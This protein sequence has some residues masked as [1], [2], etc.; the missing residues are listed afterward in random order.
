M[1]D[2][3][4]PN[5]RLKRSEK[6][7]LWDNNVNAPPQIKYD[8]F[9]NFR[10]TDIRSGLLSHLIEAFKRNQINA[11]VDD[12]L[13]RGEEI[14]PS[15]VEA[16]ERSQISLI[17]FSEDYA[18]SHWCLE[19]LVT[20]LECRKK[21]GQVVFPIFYH[22]EPRDVGKQSLEKYKKAF[23]EHETKYETK[24]QT[25]RHALKKSAKFSG[26]VTSNR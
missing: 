17:I 10:G 1:S 6:N 11:F 26:I 5:K 9:V 21:Y 4:P 24:V 23:A 25:W 20:I 7:P 22:V 2:K 16:I 18:S 8:V 3:N 14:W 13:E 15:L 19:E 12:K